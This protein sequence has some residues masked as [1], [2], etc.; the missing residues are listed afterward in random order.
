MNY[1]AIYGEVTNL[2]FNT[3]T[4]KVAQ[5]KSWVGQ[6]EIACWNSAD[7]DFKRVPMANLTV[8]AGVATEPADLG[9][10]RVLCDPRG[11]PLEYLEPDIFEREF[12][13]AAGL[14]PNIAD[15]YTVIA[16]QIIVGSTE[17]GTFKLSYRRRYTHLNNGGTPVQ[18]LMSA[19][20]DTPIWDS[21]LHYLLV[22]WALI[23]GE[24][25]EADP[26]AESLRGQRDEMLG[27]MMDEHLGGGVEARTVQYGSPS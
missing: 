9:K 13:S 26:N 3:D 7:W 5:V 14:L 27:W 25:L 16:R 19:D 17:T 21:E 22:P 12:L 20:T 1:A 23:L 10:V 24:K 2:R 4:A 8:T 15:Y 11:A 18:G 6:A